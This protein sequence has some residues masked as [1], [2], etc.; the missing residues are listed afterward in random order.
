MKMGQT[1]CPETL[2]TKQP[3]TTGNI[4]E[5]GGPQVHRWGSL[6]SRTQRNSKS[7]A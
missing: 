7:R 3:P 6:K 2:I 5:D 1:G 4:P